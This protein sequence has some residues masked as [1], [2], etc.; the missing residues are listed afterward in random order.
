[1]AEELIELQPDEIFKEDFTVKFAGLEVDHKDLV[2]ALIVGQSI[3]F[4][5]SLVGGNEARKRKIEL[6]KLNAALIKV[7]GELRREMRVAGVGPYIPA[8][9]E[10]F[11][12]KP[13]STKTPEEQEYV[14]KVV[15]QLK[16]AKRLLKE[17]ENADSL[18]LFQDALSLIN[19]NPGALTNV[20]KAARKAHR[21][22][23]AALVKMGRFTEALKAME[24][25]LRLSKEHDDFAGET[26]ALGVLADIYTDLDRLEE[27]AAFYDRYFLCLEKGEDDRQ[28]SASLSLD[29]SEDF[30]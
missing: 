26:D 3:G 6:D 19:S 1:L 16:K 7:N 11:L 4:V 28:V 29:A 21:G 8:P 27:A 5:G 23:G 12:D 25:V 15:V 2:I 9:T 14:D 18:K 20:W 10:R 24:T 22:M 13:L 17:G 30:S